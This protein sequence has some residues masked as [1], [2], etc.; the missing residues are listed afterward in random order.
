MANGS[1]FTWRELATFSHV[2]G[3]HWVLTSELLH[4]P[5]SKLLTSYG[6]SQFVVGADGR[7]SKF[8]IE[9][10]DLSS[11]VVDGW[12]WYDKIV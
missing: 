12:I 9:R 1:D 11:D 5:G 3:E 7:V 10:R 4:A 8:G 6:A 2:S